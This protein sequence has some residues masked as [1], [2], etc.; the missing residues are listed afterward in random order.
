MITFFLVIRVC[1]KICLILFE[2]NAENR[3]SQGSISVNG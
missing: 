3:F 1:L 2:I